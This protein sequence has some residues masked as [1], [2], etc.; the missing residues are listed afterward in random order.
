MKLSPQGA[1]Y[2]ITIT[3]STLYEYSVS[4]WVAP[5]K[6]CPTCRERCLLKNL[7]K[8]FV[9]SSDQSSVD[10]DDITPQEM[11]VK[12]FASSVC[13]TLQSVNIMINP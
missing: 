2:I 13:F 11:K 12:L 4:Q 7:V 6:T 9:D 3:H 10:L 5:Q 8:L 1:K